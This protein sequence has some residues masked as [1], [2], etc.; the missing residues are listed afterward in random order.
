MKHLMSWK[1]VFLKAWLVEAVFLTRTEST[2]MPSE[3][4]IHMSG[5]DL[6]GEAEILIVRQP[7]LPTRHAQGDRELD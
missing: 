4:L 2:F 5:W 3:L 7:L 6:G 1:A